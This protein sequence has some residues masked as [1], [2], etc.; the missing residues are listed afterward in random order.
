MNHRLYIAVLGILIL[1]APSMAFGQ[2]DADEEL[3][4]VLAD[5]QED[6]GDDDDDDTTV[7]RPER[8]ADEEEEADEDA[9][10]ADEGKRRG[11]VKVIQKKFFLKYRRLEVTP[12]LGYVGN[13]HFIQRLSLGLAI[14]YHINDLLEVEIFLSYLPDLDETDYKTLTKRFRTEEEVVPDI[15]RV[16]FLGVANLALSPIYGKVELGTNSIINYDIYFGAG[17]GI[18]MSKDD[19]AIIRSP[20]DAYDSVA[21]RQAH[22]EEGC[23][24]VDQVHFVT[25]AGGGLRIVFN[26]WIGIRLDARQFTHIEQV[27]RDGDIGLEMKQNFM[28]SLGASFFFPPKAR[29][30]AL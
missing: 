27:Y 1:A 18:A 29:A 12:Q 13:D 15:S 5:R 2:Q 20:C 30:L 16:T 21:E 11:I 6:E 17:F 28:I 25:N 8:D 3:D 7:A 26:E 14:G 23:Q 9:A 19:T 4:P 24:Y 10:P 22:P